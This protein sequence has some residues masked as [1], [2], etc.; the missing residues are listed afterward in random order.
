MVNVACSDMQYIP[1]LPKRDVLQLCIRVLRIVIVSI[2]ESRV[3]A[4][5][6]IALGWATYL[7]NNYSYCLA[8]YH[9]ADVLQGEP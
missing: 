5:L 3:P 6:A 7:M 9:S 2:K 1:C 8:G 4:Y